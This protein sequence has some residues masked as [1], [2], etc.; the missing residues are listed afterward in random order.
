MKVIIAF[1]YSHYCTEVVDDAGMEQE[2]KFVSGPVGGKLMLRFQ[3]L[4]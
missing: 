1:V 2:D 3:Q 4:W